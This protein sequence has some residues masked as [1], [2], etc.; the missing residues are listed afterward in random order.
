MN[1]SVPMPLKRTLV[2]APDVFLSAAD[3]ARVLGVSRRTVYE[4]V[5]S[6]DITPAGYVKGAMRI[7][8]TTLEDFVKRGRAGVLTR[9]NITKN[10]TTKSVQSGEGK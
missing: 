7:A 1:P 2:K 6:K 10:G 3:A 4:L 5:E 8:Y 9:H